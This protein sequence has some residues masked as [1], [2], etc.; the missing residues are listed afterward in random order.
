LKEINWNQIGGKGFLIEEQTF[1]V[2]P[3]GDFIQDGGPISF[4]GTKFRSSS[5]MARRIFM[6]FSAR[7]EEIGKWNSQKYCT[8]LQVMADTMLELRE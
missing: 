8:V 2:H 1:L 5:G 3:A 4:S 6:N 7:M